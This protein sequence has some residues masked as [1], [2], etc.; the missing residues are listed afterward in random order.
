M[1]H[2]GSSTENSTQRVE[3]R[4]MVRSKA[5][6]V[7]TGVHSHEREKHSYGSSKK[8]HSSCA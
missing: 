5:M 1:I 2:R 8:V 6:G 7:N 4:S 3:V